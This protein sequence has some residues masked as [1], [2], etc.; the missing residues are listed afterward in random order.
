[1]GIRVGHIPVVGT[2]EKGSSRR[3]VP[4]T[5]NVSFNIDQY[6]DGAAE[7]CDAIGDTC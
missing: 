7:S 2:V 3:K 4:R 5:G 6:G 1:M